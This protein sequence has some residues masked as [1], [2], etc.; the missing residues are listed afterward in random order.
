MQS[1][2]DHMTATALR[3]M[4]KPSAIGHPSGFSSAV[5]GGGSR[6]G[7]DDCPPNTSLKARPYISP[8]VSFVSFQNTIG[9]AQADVSVLLPIPAKQIMVCSRSNAHVSDTLFMHFVPLNKNYAGAAG[10]TM[11]GNETWLPMCAIDGAHSSIGMG[12]KFS[13]PLPV[14]GTL[15]FDIGNE[16]GGGQDIITL[17][18]SED[19][20]WWQTIVQV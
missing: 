11:I 3:M 15:Y 14:G 19:L 6:G 17:A 12:Y 20:E 16:S 2:R 9:A 13:K 1:F 5:G 7:G 8:L 10:I 4:G 18:L